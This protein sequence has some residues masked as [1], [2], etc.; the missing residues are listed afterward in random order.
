VIGVLTC[1]FLVVA[2]GLSAE[3]VRAVCRRRL[4]TPMPTRSAVVRRE[5]SPTDRDLEFAGVSDVD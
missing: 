1:L 5:P 2:T 4:L 3:A